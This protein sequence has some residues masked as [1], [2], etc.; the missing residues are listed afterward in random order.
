MKDKLI[1]VLSFALIAA[2]ALC[3]IHFSA[4]GQRGVDASNYS[5]I[6]DGDNAVLT[7]CSSD[8]S[9]VVML[10]ET[11]EGHTVTG[12]ADNAFKDFSEVTCFFLPPTLVSIGSYA[13]EG[14]TDL[15]NA[16][17]PATVRTIGKGAF[18]NCSSLISMT[19]PTAT[20]SI[21][22]CAFFGCSSLSSLIITGTTVRAAGLFDLQL[23]IGQ[24]ISIGSSS[25][26]S[27]ESDNPTTVYCHQDSE[28]YKDLLKCQFSSYKLLEDCT[29]TSYTVTYKTSDNS[30][31]YPSRTL[32]DQPVGITVVEFPA[33]I[34]GYNCESD[35]VTKI[36]VE[37][38]SANAIAFVYA[39]EE[40]TTESTTAEP[41]TEE[42]TTE[43]PTTE[44]PTTEEPTTEAPEVPIELKANDASV[45]INDT[46]NT[47]SGIPTLT[48]PE[49]L[50]TQLLNVEGNG[51][52]VFDSDKVGTGAKL[53][54]VKDGDT[55]EN[56]LK[57]YTIVIYGDVNGDG[58]ADSADLLI[59]KSVAAV[60]STLNPD[61]AF[62]IAGDIT[63]NSIVDSEDLIQ[64]KAVAA[65][66]KGINQS[67]G[68][69]YD[70]ASE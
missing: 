4:L 29:L 69:T 21:G 46:N 35:A 45:I 10:P 16:T 66:L 64:M 48:Q 9:G 41:T 62:T 3:A 63:G 22:E 54:L 8:L 18:W 20:T 15:A 52:I 23:D 44:E 17:L 57:T 53:Y 47:I 34:S 27:N 67:T 61:P 6:L 59:Y 1:R 56:A 30:T 25:V 58:N 5:Y 60:T 31:L 11:M 19:I 39:V 7:G 43:E 51:H 40:T 42:P 33:L 65:Q 24:S 36:L 28:A 12:I 32:S 37:D 14:C 26:F 13:F 49:V 38:E 55:K 50:T 70:I 2:V 68:R